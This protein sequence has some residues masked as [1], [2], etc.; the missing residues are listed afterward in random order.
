M[1]WHPDIV[2]LTIAFA[3]YSR[4]SGNLAVE[5][6][7]YRINGQMPAYVWALAYL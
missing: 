6:I 1:P 2:G 7:N 3:I 5:R 4:H